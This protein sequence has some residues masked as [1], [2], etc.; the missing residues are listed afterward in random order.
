MA[1]S[2]RI[3]MP[4]AALLLSTVGTSLPALAQQAADTPDK[5]NAALAADA[6]ATP[7]PDG[8]AAP[9]SADPVI[10]PQKKGFF[11]RFIDEEDHGLDFSNFLA[12]GG[13]IPVPIIITEP[14]VDG[15]F[16][17]AAAFLS[18]NKDHPRQIT[19]TAIA[20]FKT[21][22]G[23]DGIGAFRSGYAFDGRLNYRIGIGH[24]KITLDAFPA[25]LPEGLEYTNHYKYGIFGSAFW[26]LKDD[27]FSFGP[28]FD[29]RKLQSRIDITGLPDD[30]ADD[31]NRTMKTGALGAGFH[32][33]NRD[34]PVTP[35]RGTNAY[36]E[37]K[38][39][40]DAFGSKRDFE[41]YNVEAYS[42]D[43]FTS[44]LR[45]GY[46]FDLNMIRGDF[47]AYFAP[48]INLRGVQA[49]EYQG[50]TVLSTEL[51]LTWQ[52]SP[53]WSLLGFGG[54]GT[55]DGGDRRIFRDSGD[56]WAGGAGFRYKLARK[57]GLDAGMDFAYGPGG[58]VFYIQFGHAWSFGMD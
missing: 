38:F 44:D 15:G 40:R 37:A 34:N 30:F 2:F 41:T 3:R 33:D 5:A 57:L 43:K 42:F 31:F 35:T 6:P 18:A 10:T 24:G 13:F 25:F 16:G 32:F 12:K 9:A 4:A 45:F 46:K 47:P 21:G 8:Q 55:T 20:A 26:H 54:Y 58:F 7:P 48:A 36:V 27:R 39:D 17:L 14:A 53:R 49:Q 56:V 22:N 52:V 28:L 19:K 1:K 29:F 51:E 11:S 50:S 23:S